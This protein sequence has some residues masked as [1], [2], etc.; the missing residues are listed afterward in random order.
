MTLIFKSVV[1]A[2]ALLQLVVL[3][4]VW[5]DPA[6]TPSPNNPDFCYFRNGKALCG[7]EGVR[8]REEDR[9][10]V[11]RAR[12]R[13]Q[14]LRRPASG[15]GADFYVPR[16]QNDEPDPFIRRQ[17]AVND[18]G[19]VPPR[20]QEFVAPPTEVVPPPPT[21][22]TRAPCPTPP[23]TTTTTTQLPCPPATTTQRPCPLAPTTTTLPPCPYAP[24]TTTTTTQSPCEVW[25]A[26]QQ[27]QLR[28]PRAR[29]Q[30]QSD[31]PLTTSSAAD[32]SEHREFDVG[33]RG[34]RLN[35]N[36]R[37]SGRKEDSLHRGTGHGAMATFGH[38]GGRARQ[39][40]QAGRRV[41]V[42]LGVN[43][44]RNVVA[45]AD[46]YQRDQPQQPQQQP[47]ATGGVGSRMPKQ[48]KAD[49]QKNG[50]MLWLYHLFQR[51]N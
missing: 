42:P 17:A 28:R 1:A 14:Q 35:F 2:T 19:N 21:T 47:I 38:R 41:V 46:S 40:S 26:Q 44:D 48:K 49:D 25:R 33:R 24:T 7:E 30:F 31:Q 20:E 3:L 18:K 27:Q 29:N 50:G 5:A 34:L 23:P 9:Q 32:L 13:A 8:A 16:L 43:E 15:N 6:V 10:R 39:Q 4:P 22:T 51:K 36:N 11:Q 45:A 37:N 12:Q